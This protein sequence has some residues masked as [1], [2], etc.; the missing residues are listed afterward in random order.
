MNYLEKREAMQNEKTISKNNTEQQTTDVAN[1]SL[2]TVT[3]EILTL[4]NHIAINIIEIG[5]RLNTVKDNIEFGEFGK[6]LEEKVDFSQRT[7]NNFMKIA[8]EFPNSQ[9]VS[10][11]GTRK[12]LMLAGVETEKRE[13]IM[14]ECN[15]SE[16]TGQELEKVIQDKK[17]AIEKNKKEPR[18]TGKIEKALYKKYK[19]KFNNDKE[20]SNLVEFLLEKYFDN[21]D[22]ID[23]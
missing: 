17:G 22:K 21:T 3:S 4:K 7:A 13:E 18:F 2:E 11:L 12:L 15:V 8:K 9:P 19:Y 16:I 23:V 20:F 6:W 14:Q 1:F 10:N 5:K